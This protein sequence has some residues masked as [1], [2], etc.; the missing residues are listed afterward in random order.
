MR[1]SPQRQCLESRLR[2]V[3]ISEEAG[4]V[5]VR[6]LETATT[7]QSLL[8]GLDLDRA[9]YTGSLSSSR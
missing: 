4:D 2:R 7:R 5:L 8:E 9:A 1:V 3:E 6:P